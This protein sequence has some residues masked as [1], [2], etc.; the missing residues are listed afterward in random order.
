MAIHVV[1]SAEMWHQFFFQKT[2]V[3]GRCQLVAVQFDD[4]NATLYGQ[5]EPGF[6][7]A[8]LS[9]KHRYRCAHLKLHVNLKAVLRMGL[10]DFQH[11]N[12]I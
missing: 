1:V 7:S 9:D 6:P 2:N 11:G 5:K 4:S 10:V 3:S 8:V 12:F